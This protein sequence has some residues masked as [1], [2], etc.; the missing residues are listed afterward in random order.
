MKS[1]ISSSLPR[2][3]V[4]DLTRAVA[5]ST[6]R[7]EVFDNTAASVGLNLNF[8]VAGADID[9]DVTVDF[10]VSGAVYLAFTMLG[11]D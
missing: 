6:T 8:R 9:D 3:S 4:S 10:T 1:P 7:G 2:D 5:L 11:D